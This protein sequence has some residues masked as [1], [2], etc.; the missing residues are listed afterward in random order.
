MMFI[1]IQLK[2]I[3]KTVSII[4]LKI[5]LGGI[6]RHPR[7]VRVTVIVIALRSDQIRNI[8]SILGIYEIRP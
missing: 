7:E 1:M 3:I 4:L 2:E 8:T 6:R 5:R